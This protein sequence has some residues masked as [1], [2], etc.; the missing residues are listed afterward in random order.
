MD[1]VTLIRVIAGALAVVIVFIIIWR[2]KK[3]SVE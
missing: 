2:R 3:K 1:N